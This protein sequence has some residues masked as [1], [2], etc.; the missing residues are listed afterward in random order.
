MTKNVYQSGFYPAVSLDYGG[1]VEL[2]PYALYFPEMPDTNKNFDLYNKWKQRGGKVPKQ[3]R[4]PYVHIEDL[5]P[6]IATNTTAT[7]PRTTSTS[8]PTATTIS[9]PGFFSRLFRNF[10]SSTKD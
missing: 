10:G 1:E 3:K 4:Q 6:I 9:R 5:T 8:S 2:C 7:T